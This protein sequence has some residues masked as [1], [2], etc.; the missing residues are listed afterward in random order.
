MY[1]LQN[2]FMEIVFDFKGKQSLIVTQ[3]FIIK[4]DMQVRKGLAAACLTVSVWILA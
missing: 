2:K 1:T 4:L 3:D